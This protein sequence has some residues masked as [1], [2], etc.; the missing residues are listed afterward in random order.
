[1]SQEDYF[2][3]NQLPENEIC[4]LR[5]YGV[6]GCIKN[7]ITSDKHRDN[8]YLYDIINNIPTKTKYVAKT[9]TE[10]EKYIHTETNMAA[11]A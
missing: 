9:P 2:I 5:Y 1:M 8:Y 11:T 6:D 3:L 7:I 4:W 10:F